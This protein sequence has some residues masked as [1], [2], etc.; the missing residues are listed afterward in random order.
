MESPLGGGWEQTSSSVR[1]G[2]CCWAGLVLSHLAAL[3]AALEP[4]RAKP[5]EPLRPV[6]V[7]LQLFSGKTVLPFAWEGKLG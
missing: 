4:R 6:K 2:C 7:H 1:V 3:L 5:P